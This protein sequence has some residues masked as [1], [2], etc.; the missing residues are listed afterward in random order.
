MKIRTEQRVLLQALHAVRGIVDKKSTLNVLAHVLI[1]TVGKDAFRVSATDYDAGLVAVYPCEVEE[2]GKCCV[3]ATAALAAVKTLPD[4]P[5]ALATM[6]NHWLEVTCAKAK[7]HLLGIP[8]ED[9]PE[10]PRPEEA[11]VAVLDRSALLGV[12]DHCAPCMSSDESRMNLCGILLEL[13]AASPVDCSTP[14]VRAQATATDGH[15]LAHAAKSVPTPDAPRGEVRAILHRKGAAELRQLLTSGEDE[16]V[17]VGTHENNLVFQ[18]ENAFLTVRV[19][20][21]DYPAYQAIIPRKTTTRITVEKA[22]LAAALRVAASVTSSKVSLVRMTVDA[23]ECRVTFHGWNPDAGDATAHCDAQVDGPGV[24]IGF[25][26]SYL[27]AAIAAVDGRDV[28]IACT[29]E[30][31]PVLVT[32]D[33][34][35]AALTVVMPMRLSGDAPAADAPDGADPAEDAAEAREKKFF[36][37]VVLPGIE[38]ATE[39]ERD[40]AAVARDRLI[41]LGT[42]EGGTLTVGTVGGP[43]TTFTAADGDAARARLAGDAA[44]HLLRR[45]ADGPLPKFSVWIGQPEQAAVAKPNAFLTAAKK[46]LELQ[47]AVRPQPGVYE[48]TEAG[49][50][51]C[52][53]TE[54]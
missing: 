20:E 25:S 49:R 22:V 43:Q 12:V 46:L 33:D 39:K 26:A 2:P 30:A 10:M 6:P 16:A 11:C 23:A 51:A 42:R 48:L 1:E 28:R 18:Y 32:S 5:C 37:E 35:D 54:A 27:A 3:A 41:D 52:A 50:A 19:I 21:D 13:A 14:A 8:P 17:S 53:T 7:L 9:F 38:K 29:D 47:L 34:D 36:E 31:S 40:P 45:L 4:V 44:R 15:R 24:T